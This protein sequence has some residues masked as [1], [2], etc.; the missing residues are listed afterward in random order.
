MAKKWQKFVLKKPKRISSPGGLRSSLANGGHFVVYTTDDKR[1]EF[2]LEYLKS[3]LFVELMR[4]SEEEFGLPTDGPITLP[5]ESLFLEYV[6]SL[7]Y[8]GHLAKEL[9]KALLMINS[10]S[11]GH[12]S[13]TTS[14]GWCIRPISFQFVFVNDQKCI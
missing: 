11:I 1:C 10:M 12:Y 5:C 8:K 6:I 4:M 14:F 2:P 7:A 9:E 3:S 13:T